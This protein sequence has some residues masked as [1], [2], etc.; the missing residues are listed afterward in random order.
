MQSAQKFVTRAPW[1]KKPTDAHDPFL[2]IEPFIVDLD[3][4]WLF[5]NL[6]N[7]WPVLPWKLMKRDK[8]NESWMQMKGN[9]TNMSRTNHFTQLIR[10][11]KK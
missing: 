8:A 7:I 11:K 5:H 2:I 4:Y 9:K 1:E 10:A 3:S 6:L